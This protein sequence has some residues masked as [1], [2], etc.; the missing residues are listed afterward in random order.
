M[1]TNSVFFQVIDQGQF[2]D[3]GGARTPQPVEATGWEVRVR[4]HATFALLAFV[5]EFV[6]LSVGPEL[7]A[8]GNGSITLDAD[9][10]F[11]S[12]TLLN[13]EDASTLT[14]NENIWQCF[15]DGV[16]RFEFIGRTIEETQLDDSESRQLK[17][18]GPGTAELLKWGKILPPG[19]PKPPPDGL[20]PETAVTAKNT[21]ATLG[22][23]FPFHWPAMQ[24]WWTLLKACQSRGTLR[25]IAPTFTE[26]KDSAGIAWV[27]VPTIE[28][29]SKYSGFRP[30]M[31]MDLLDFLNQCTG[32]DYDKHFAD[33]NEW[34]MH[35]GFRLEVR[36]TI[37]VNRS[38]VGIPGVAVPG[39]AVV[40]F[41]EGVL[42]QKERTRV[43]EE[44]ANYLAVI[45]VNGRFSF[46]ADSP[47]IKQWGQREQLQNQN[48]N[49]TD[50]TLR[51]QLAH[52]YLDK[53]KAEKSEWVIQ[54]PY[55]QEGRRPFR[56]YA[57]GDW[58]GIANYTPDRGSSF[59]AYRILAIVVNID[60]DGAGTVELTLQSKI[61]LRD[62]QLQNKITNII[63]TINEM[64]GKLPGD[65]KSNDG[66]STV[67]GP[68]T[69]P[70]TGAGTDLASLLNGAA[71]L[72]RV[73]IQDTDPGDKAAIGDFWFNT[74]FNNI[75]TV[76]PPKEPQPQTPAVVSVPDAIGRF[77]VPNPAY[78]YGL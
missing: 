15:E 37:G 7:N 43:R 29:A 77:R 20:D 17:V 67:T 45:D 14:D 2:E 39:G 9:H 19:F 61:E 25:F 46:A 58:I 28:T 75:E 18:S 40:R 6:E 42:V 78:E 21:V 24:M 26:T 71:G 66:D 53:A 34:F 32:Q 16:L 50:A 35:P 47:S 31:G 63:N 64:N 72:G 10:P 11:W 55:A 4:D 33:R 69:T 49:I 1:A 73:W 60:E 22:W 52:A 59:D 13:G 54:V 51:T 68:E 5:P 56:D 65:Q 48:L 27:Y 57:V 70:A 12:Y 38:G 30:E 8:S 36:K 3:F 74:A 23:E 62:K 76:P 44:I 41:F